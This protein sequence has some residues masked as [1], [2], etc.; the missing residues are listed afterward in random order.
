MSEQIRVG[1]VVEW[2]WASG[3]ATGKVTGLSHHRVER[4]IK[5][6]TIVRNGSDDDPAVDIEQDDGSKVLKLRSELE[7]A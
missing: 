5:G 1:T 3:T 6:K 7:R 2:S 4:T